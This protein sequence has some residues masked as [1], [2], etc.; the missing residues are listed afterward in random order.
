MLLNDAPSTDTVVRIASAHW[1]L[2]TRALLPTLITD[3]FEVTEAAIHAVKDAITAGTPGVIGLHL[4][5]PHLSQARKGAHKG[6]LIRP[7]EDRDLNLLLQAARTL[8]RLKITIA[9][10]N[11]TTDQVRALAQAGV[12]VSLGHTGTDYATL[13][14][15]TSGPVRAA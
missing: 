5:G 4:E 12:L 9:P 13:S 7:M 14:G 3:T 10:E 1:R 11:V 15:P 8:P 6:D 2:G